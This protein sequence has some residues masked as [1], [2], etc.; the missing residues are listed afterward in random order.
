M[1]QRKLAVVGARGKVMNGCGRMGWNRLRRLKDGR[2]SGSNNVLNMMVQL[3]WAL[4]SLTGSYAVSG[5]EGC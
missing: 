2:T 3:V 4:S 5:R 1:G